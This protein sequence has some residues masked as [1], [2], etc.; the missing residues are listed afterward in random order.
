MNFTTLLSQQINS[1]VQVLTRHWWLLLLLLTDWM[2]RHR[3]HLFL[4]C[5]LTKCLGHVS[6]GIWTPQYGE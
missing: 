3:I 1:L 5:L 2:T 4:L 6:Y